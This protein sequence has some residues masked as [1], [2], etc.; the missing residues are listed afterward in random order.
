MKKLTIWIEGCFW[1][2]KNRF[3]TVSPNREG[4][5]IPLEC[6]LEDVEKDDY[7]PSRH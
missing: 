3:C 5:R 2:P 7:I 1:C 6:P 4:W